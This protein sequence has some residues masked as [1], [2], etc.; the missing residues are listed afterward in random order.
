MVTANISRTSTSKADTGTREFK[1]V[2][3]MIDW[4]LTKNMEI[5][6]SNGEERNGADYDI[7]IYDDYRE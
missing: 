5:V 1:D 6:V 4:A 7:E 2:K 3:E